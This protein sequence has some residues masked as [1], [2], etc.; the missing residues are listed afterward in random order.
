MHVSRRPNDTA[1][2][3][4]KRTIAAQLHFLGLLLAIGGMFI[5]LHAAAKNPDPAH[6]WA[7]LAFSIPS[8]LVFGTSAVY[9]FLSDG[10][11]VSARLEHLFENLD[12]FSIYLFIAGTYT[13]FL[14][15]AVVPPW[16]AILLIMIWTIALSG[17]LYT[18]CKPKLPRW[19][20]HRFLYTGLFVLM[21]WTLMIR[22]GEIFDRLTPHAAWLLFAGALCYTLGAIVY[23]TQRPRLY[24]GLFGFHELWHIMV[25]AG[26]A[27]HY[28]LILDFYRT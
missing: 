21:G 9:H 8:M 16:R 14:M 7:C 20:Q 28:F 5:L 24:V 13:P 12:H 1:K 26:F 17:I 23:A 11:Q 22:A 25:L 10:H 4:F 6:Y 18:L 3:Y 2:E 15:N 19:M 27:C